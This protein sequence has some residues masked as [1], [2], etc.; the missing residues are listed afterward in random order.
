M[1]ATKGNAAL[2]VLVALGALTGCGGDDK[3]ES[4]TPTTSAP[5]A[6]APNTTTPPPIYSAAQ[7]KT[8]L[9]TAREVGSGQREI[10]IAADFLNRRRI[11]MCSLTE[12]KP[13]GNPQLTTREF[14][15]KTNRPGDEIGYYQLIA[16]YDSPEDAGRAYSELRK[17]AKACP[18]KRRVPA[19]RVRANFTSLA[20]DDTWKVTEDTV[21]GWKHVRGYERREFSAS[22]TKANIFFFMYDYAVRG[23]VV[24]TSLYTERRD[25]GEPG[26]PVAKNATKTL[27]K[28]LEKLG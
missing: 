12:L 13:S 9:L 17:K 3:P 14:R 18:A 27:T 16:R 20:H 2:A 5:A 23:N 11:P 8:R 6:P 15:N 4:A 28:Q 24:L 21:A 7:L 19:K 26:E 10:R 22:A 1:I 25:P